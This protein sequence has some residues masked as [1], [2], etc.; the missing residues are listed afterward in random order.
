MSPIGLRVREE[1]HKRG[2][3][4]RELARRANVRQATVSQLERGV[5]RLDLVILEKVA[6]ALKVSPEKLLTHTR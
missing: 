1:R 5:R 6:R 4:Q 2:W 3:S